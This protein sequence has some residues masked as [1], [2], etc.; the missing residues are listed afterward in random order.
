M[1][2]SSAWWLPSP[3]VSTIWLQHWPLGLTVPQ[4]I[5]VSQRD[6][7]VS[8]W[9]TLE[10]PA[11][12]LQW[13]LAHWENANVQAAGRGDT[14]IPTPAC[15]LSSR[16]TPDWDRVQPLSRRLL[17]PI[18]SS[19][20]LSTSHSSSGSP[21]ARGHSMSQSSAL[22]AR[23]WDW[24]ARVSTLGCRLKHAVPDLYSSIK[25]VILVC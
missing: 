20:Y 13:T 16:A 23:D 6:N 5:E 4:S 3:P 8:R 22:V 2:P 1:T 9:S 24:S 15:R 7:R 17:N 19:R 18:L 10:P 12:G 11:Q 21:S 25:S 14:K